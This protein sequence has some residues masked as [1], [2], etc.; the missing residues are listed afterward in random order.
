MEKQRDS[1][2]PPRKIAKETVVEQNGF[3]WTVVEYEK[4]EKGNGECLPEKSPKKEPRPQ[5]SQ[6]KKSEG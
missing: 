2:E 5:R 6:K 3:I 1:S 4:E